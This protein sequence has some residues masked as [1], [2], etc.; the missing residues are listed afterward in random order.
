MLKQN[1][2]QPRDSVSVFNVITSNH[3]SASL[4][5]LHL[6]MRC[7]LPVTGRHYVTC[8]SPKWSSLAAVDLLATCL[9]WPCLRSQNSS[10]A[11]WKPRLSHGRIS[12]FCA[13]KGDRFCC[14]RLGRAKVLHTLQA[15][16]IVHQ[17]QVTSRT[18]PTV[19]RA[20]TSDESCM[21]SLPDI[22]TPNYSH[23]HR[24]TSG[25]RLTKLPP[26]RILLLGS[27]VHPDRRPPEKSQRPPGQR[28]P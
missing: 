10:S 7:T 9:S 17:Y 2:G 23:Q 1:I 4:F 28:R 27:A 12:V 26:Q 16:D 21:Q 19:P 8:H 22:S 13:R 5:A 11:R 18:P 24:E 14:M 20:L 3:R 15:D 25:T 6:P